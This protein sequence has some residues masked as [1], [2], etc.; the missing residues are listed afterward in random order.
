[1]KPNLKWTAATLVVL[2]AAT[3]STMHALAIAPVPM[4]HERDGA[5]AAHR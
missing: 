4:V 5:S 2:S 3:V 1:M